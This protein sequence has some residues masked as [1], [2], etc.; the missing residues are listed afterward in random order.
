MKKVMLNRREALRISL[1]SSALLLITGCSSLRKSESE[2]A[3]NPQNCWLS[4]NRILL[5]YSTFWKSD[6]PE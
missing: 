2:Q 3:S 4:A 6:D 1:A 5:S